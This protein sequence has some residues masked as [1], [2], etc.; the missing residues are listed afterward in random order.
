MSPPFTLYTFGD[1]MLDCGIYNSRGIT[2]GA[3]L[4][5]NDDLL[6]PEF[7]GRDLSSRGPATLVHRAMDG[8]TVAGL[9]LQMRELPEGIGAALVTIGGNDLLQGLVLDTGPGI[10]RFARELDAI[11]E[12]LP[13]RPVYLGNV[14]DPTFGDDA[15]NFLGVDAALARRNLNRMNETLAALAARHGQLV[16]IHAHFLTGEPS[17]YTNII[18]PSLRG[19]SEVRR[20]FL[21]ALER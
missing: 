5:K 14:Y 3:L 10:E 2:P 9:R 19:A 20:A 15:Q 8:A 16:D 18:E 13:V 4:V 12:E 21:D 6:F 1:S 7:S 11:L 17:W